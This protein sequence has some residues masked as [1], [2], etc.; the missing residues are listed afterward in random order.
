M[1]SNFAYILNYLDCWTI[2]QIITVEKTDKSIRLKEVF[3]CEDIL[4]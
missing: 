1:G 3:R 4:I 2:E